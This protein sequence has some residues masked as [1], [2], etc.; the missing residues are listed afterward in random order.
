MALYITAKAWRPKK[1]EV[2]H[3][4][5]ENDDPKAWSYNKY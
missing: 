2:S 3:L 5:H 1:R 4:T